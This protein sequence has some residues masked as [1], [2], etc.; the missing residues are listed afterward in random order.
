VE[1]SLALE[2]VG[3]SIA[4]N[5]HQ[6]GL[7]E[8]I[9]QAGLATALRGSLIEPMWP[10]GPL[11]A[12]GARPAIPNLSDM[13]LL[14]YANIVGLRRVWLA[15]ALWRSVE[16]L[17]A[18]RGKPQAILS[19][20]VSFE[21]AQ[22]G[23]H[24]QKRHGIPWVVVYADTVP[25][26]VERHFNDKWLARAA[27]RVFLSWDR[28]ERCLDLPKFHLDHGVVSL[29]KGALA[30][31]GKTASSKS[32]LFAGT[33]CAAT[34][35]DRLAR[36]F[37]LVK[38]PDARLWICGK[39][40]FRP[41]Q[42][43]AAADERIEIFGAVPEARLSE[44]AAKARAFVNPRPP[45]LPENRENFPSKLV[46]YL[47]YGKPVV[48]SWTPG[49]APHYREVLEVVEPFTELALANRMEDILQRPPSA[50]R[51]SEIED[52]VNKRKLWRVQ[53]ER[54]VDW[55]QHEIFAERSRGQ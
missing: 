19:Y 38:D 6:R 18:K 12:A 20:N 15:G 29:P 14:R 30:A 11:F 55:L 45:G 36:A 21:S 13:K 34:G 51:K 32:F 52:F 25:H 9:E 48:S 42:E 53:G 41:L 40:Q 54:L 5:R 17:I 1:D 47:A 23:L 8:G 24:Y 16:K 22:L 7:L 43:A 2:K 33:L 27:G 3:V 49:I 39:G 35:V 37:R 26:A 46:D 10:R 4:A 44:L 28:Y 31:G 50:D